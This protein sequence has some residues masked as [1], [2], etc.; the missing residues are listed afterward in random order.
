M[1]VKEHLTE[2]SGNDYIDSE[3]FSKFSVKRG[4]RNDDGTGVLVGLTRVGDV[5]GYDVTD[6][7]K[8]AVPGKLFYRGINVEQIAAEA[9]EQNR[10]CFEETIY[11]LLFGK[12]PTQEQLNDFN[13]LIGENRALPNHFV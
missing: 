9:A 10:F 8:T 5:H 3:L 2:I 13:L 6:G 7:K 1:D 4:L 11:L 12:L